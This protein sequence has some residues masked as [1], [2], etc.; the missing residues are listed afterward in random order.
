MESELLQWIATTLAT[1]V[2]GALL[3]GVRYLAS[4]TSS[5]MLRDAAGRLGLACRTAVAEVKQT[6]VDAIKE[7]AADGKLTDAERKEAM[8]RAIGAAK[9]LLG[10]KGLKL[11]GQAF[12][13]ISGEVDSFLTSHLE[14]AVADKPS[15]LRTTPIDP[16]RE[17]PPD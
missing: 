6:Y 3:F 12:G 8:G 1:V 13:I 9:S 15:E 16:S 2:T 14:A 17:S 4:K 5:D 10:V 7:G 11:V